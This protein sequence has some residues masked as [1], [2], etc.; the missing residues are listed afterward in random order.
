MNWFVYLLVGFIAI[1]PTFWLAIKGKEW[2]NKILFK[3][4]VEE[5]SPKSWPGDIV[6]TAVFFVYSVIIFNYM[7]K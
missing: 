6:A 4:E 1:I 2:T 7:P 3:N 5:S